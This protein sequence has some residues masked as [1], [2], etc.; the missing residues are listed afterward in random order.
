MASDIIARIMSIKDPLTTITEEL[1]HAY[2]AQTDKKDGLARVCAR[3]A[4]GWAVQEHLKT[5][6][7]LDLKTSSAYEYIQFMKT[8]DNLPSRV[9]QTLSYLTTKLEK[10]SLETEAYWP[11]EKIDLV[12]EAHWL[13]EELLQTK[14]E[15]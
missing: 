1:R 3:R 8:Q 4:A 13:V 11:L 12:A 6:A 7:G 15:L 2:Q 5:T 10:E 14:I 9:A